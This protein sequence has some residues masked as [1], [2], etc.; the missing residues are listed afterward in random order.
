MHRSVVVT[1]LVRNY[2]N[3]I[4]NYFAFSVRIV[5]CKQ[6]ITENEFNE[7]VKQYGPSNYDGTMNDLTRFG[8][9]EFPQPDMIEKG[10]TLYLTTY[11]R[12]GDW[13]EPTLFGTCDRVLY[14]TYKNNMEPFKVVYP[15][16]MNEYDIDYMLVSCRDGS[17]NNINNYVSLGNQNNADIQSI[18]TLTDFIPVDTETHRVIDFNFKF[19]Y[20]VEADGLPYKQFN[21]P[22]KIVQCKEGIT[23][24]EFKALVVKYGPSNYDGTMGKL[25]EFNF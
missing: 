14:M 9:G 6:H 10:K 21:I 8:F 16:D 15:S 13:Y 18:G 20:F 24:E 1:F 5:Q 12:E 7:L 19:K 22:Y 11:E 23:K 2:N 4:G 3:T 25:D 17:D